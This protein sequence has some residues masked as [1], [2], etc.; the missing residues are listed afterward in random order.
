MQLRIQVKPNKLVT[1]VA[2]TDEGLL[3]E[4]KSKPIKG[5]ANTEL[6]KI[7]SDHFKIPKTH[8]RIIRGANSRHKTIEIPDIH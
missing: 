7:L 5:A 4:L 3:I 8:I 2:A 1:R 6:I